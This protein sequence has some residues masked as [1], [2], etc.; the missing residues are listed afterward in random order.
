MWFS[1]QIALGFR[2]LCLVYLAR[3]GYV[4]KL[5]GGRNSKGPGWDWGLWTTTK[6][7][8]FAIKC[9][10]VDH[11]I[12]WICNYYIYDYI[13]FTSFLIVIICCLSTLSRCAFLHV[14][15]KTFSPRASDSF[16]MLF[17]QLSSH[18][19]YIHPRF[20]YFQFQPR[21]VLYS[22]ALWCVLPSHRFMSEQK[23]GCPIFCMD[24]SASG[25]VCV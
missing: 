3:V 16:D 6:A 15:P 14:F 22:I 17:L 4:V 1:G 24:S 9:N 21:L 7:P 18:H 19:A 8:C 25:I 5:D 23:D 11:Q 12:F 13:I 10:H 2:G 20:N